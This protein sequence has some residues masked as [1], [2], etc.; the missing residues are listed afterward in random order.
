MTRYELG[1]DMFRVG[2]YLAQDINKL[3]SVHQRRQMKTHKNGTPYEYS[4]TC[5]DLRQLYI[6]TYYQLRHALV[7]S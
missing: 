7:R 5:S 1:T 2:A 4:S 3:R 6:R